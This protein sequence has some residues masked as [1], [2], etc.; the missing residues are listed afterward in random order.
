MSVDSRLVKDVLVRELLRRAEGHAEQGAGR[1][2]AGEH[3]AMVR[4]GYC[5]RLAE[6]DL[7]EPAR[8]PLPGLA[9]R[10]AKEAAMD[11][12]R[13]LAS[14]EPPG[15]VLLETAFGGSRVVDML[16]GDPLP[17]IC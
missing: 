10:M 5:A 6:T 17:R 3:S 15:L 12:S 8:A 13:E 14:A 16:A 9:E 2:L 4:L 11:V 7:F 1:H